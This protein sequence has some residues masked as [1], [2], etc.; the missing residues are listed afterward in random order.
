LNGLETENGALA[1]VKLIKPRVFPDDRGFFTET[2]HVEKYRT[3][4]I[5]LPFVQDNASYSSQNVLRGLH[6][7]KQFPQGKLVYVMAGEI[8]DVAADI[9]PDSPTFGQWEGH[10]LSAENH[11]QLYVP[12]GCAHGFLVL[13]E[14]A[15]VMYKCTDIYR[16]SDDSGLIWNDPF[17]AIDWPVSDPILSPKDAVLPSFQPAG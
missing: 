17:F 13:S 1:G 5:D 4:G 6:F 10:R 3:A 16:P 15:L 2:Y 14:T 7:Q 8:Y 11:H 9:R 12:P